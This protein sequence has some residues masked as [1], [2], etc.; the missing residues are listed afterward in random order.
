MSETSQASDDNNI[1]IYLRIKPKLA[2][3]S[4]N[5]EANYIKISEDKKCLSLNLSPENES[6]FYFDNIFNEKESQSSIFEIIGK[7]LCHNILQ[8]INSTFISYGKKNTG[9]TY[10]IRG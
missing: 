6:K 10:T 3:D 4:K 7:P 2:N 1:K 8:G 9:K 5:E